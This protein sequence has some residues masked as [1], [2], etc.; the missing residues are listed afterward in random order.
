MALLC[1]IMAFALKNAVEYK[2]KA[3]FKVV[4]SKVFSGMEFEIN[5]YKFLKRFG[6]SDD[7]EFERRDV[8]EKAKEIV[9]KVN[10]L[11]IEEQRKLLESFVFPGEKG[12][13]KGKGKG[14]EEASSEDLLPPLPN[15]EKIV[16]RF[17]PEPNGYLHIGHAKA[18]FIDYVYAKKYN[19]R[20]LLR[21][22]DTNPLKEEKIYYDAQKRGFKMAWNRVG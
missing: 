2:G 14:K 11:T 17:P 12:K 16:T 9:K 1:R 10:T 15:P 21:F 22:D 8:A 13:G 6:Y 18:A 7:E 20:F 19:G 4:V 3:S 5:D